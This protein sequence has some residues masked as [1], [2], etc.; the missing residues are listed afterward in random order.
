L[1]RR[2]T[3]ERYVVKKATAPPTVHDQPSGAGV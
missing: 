3:E 1:R 2:K